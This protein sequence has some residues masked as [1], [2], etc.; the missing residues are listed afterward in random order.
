MRL[1][2][3]MKIALGVH[4]ISSATGRWHPK[5]ATEAYQHSHISFSQFGEDLAVAS[6]LQSMDHQGPVSYLDIGCFKPIQYSNTYFFY[7]RGGSGIA[8][9]L[10]ETHRKEFERL[11]PR[12]QFIP[13]L[14]SNSPHPLQVT[15]NGMFNDKVARDKSPQAGNWVQPKTLAD[16]LDTHWPKDKQIALLDVDCEG[17]D[18]EVLKSN[19]WTKY[20]PKVVLVEDFS[21]EEVSAVEV[22]LQEVGYRKIARLRCAVFFVEAAS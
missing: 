19:N 12:D 7:A 8:V 14:V 1:I 3:K 15:A 2:Q 21:N 16:L 18:L 6:I 11:R 20:R 17:H 13:A 10:N 5:Y 9:D 22:F 4:L